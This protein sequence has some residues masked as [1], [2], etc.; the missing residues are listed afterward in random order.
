MTAPRFFCCSLLARASASEVLPNLH[1][2]RAYLDLDL[3][4]WGCVLDVWI[5]SSMGFRVERADVWR[6]LSGVLAPAPVQ[7]EK[8]SLRGALLVPSLNA[9]CCGRQLQLT[10]ATQDACYV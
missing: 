6:G 8:G 9:W 1:A 7:P 2:A 3:S 10:G 4:P 5:S